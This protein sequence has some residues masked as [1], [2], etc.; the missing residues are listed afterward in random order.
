MRT[1]KLD[2]KAL[3]VD[4]LLAIARR[5][6]VL[7]VSQDGASF[8]LEEADDFEREVTQLGNSEKFMKFLNER[9]HEK[10]A[11]SIE[12]FAGELNSTDV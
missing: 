12:Q 7:L 4:E 2:K 10:S 3:S 9:T 11:T 6:A 1:I 5:E 8:V